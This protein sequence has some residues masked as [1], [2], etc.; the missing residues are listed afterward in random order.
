MKKLFLVIV[1]LL[2]NVSLPAQNV[3]I[4]PG[5]TTTIET[6]AVYNSDFGPSNTSGSGFSCNFNKGR[7]ILSIGA[8]TQSD[9]YASWDEVHIAFYYNGSWKEV[10]EFWMNDNQTGCDL[11]T[12][13]DINYYT[14]PW[15]GC[16]YSAGTYE[17]NSTIPG[18][19][20]VGKMGG[21]FS[22]RYQNITLK[23]M[24]NLQVYHG[25]YLAQSGVLLNRITT[26]D[27]YMWGIQTANYTTSGTSYP[28]YND[29]NPSTKKSTGY[30]VGNY[31]QFGNLPGFVY[32]QFTPN[33]GVVIINIAN[34]PPD[35]LDAPNFK[36]HIYA[37]SNGNN[38]NR[39]YE[40]TYSNQNFLT[41][42]PNTLTAS[43]NLCGKVTLNW[44]NSN[45][46]LPDDGNVTIKNV[47]FRNGTYLATID[48]SL[49]TYDDV[50]AVQDVTYKYTVKHV[51]FSETGETYY[52][53]PASAVAEGSVKP[54]PEQPISPTASKNTCDGIINVGWSFNGTNPQYFRLDYSTSSSGP[55]TT[56]SSTITGSSRSYNHTGA[57]RGQQYYYRIY[58]INSCGVISTTYADCNGIS[59]SDPALPTPV[60]AVLNASQDTIT[61]SWIDNANNETKYQIQ[62]QDNLGNLVTYDVN[63]NITSF[64]DYG[65]TACRSYTYS[66][67]VFN[68]CVQSGLISS[69]ISSG[70][71]P[72][73]N[74]NTTFTSSKKL[75]CSKGYFTN[76]VELNWTN[77]YGQN[78][79]IFKIYRKING[80][81]FDSTLVGTA[82]AGSGFYVDNTADARV[83]YKYTIVGIK[84][85]NGTD[86]LSNTSEDIGF[87][88][89][90]GVVSGHIE[91]NGGIA[92]TGAKVIIQQAG[93]STGSSLKFAAGD[94]L[95]LENP[96]TLGLTNQLRMEFW[97]K[98]TSYSASQN[99]INKAG[100]FS[101]K[102]TGSSYVALI[103]VGGTNYTL[104][105]PEA[106]F[107][108]NQWKHVSI[109]YLGDSTR[110]AL[111]AD[112]LLAVSATVPN[113]TIN[114]IS[115]QIVMGG[116]S[117]AFLMDEF[118]L[119]A[120][121]A[122]LD[123]TIYIDH[124][125]FLN[126]S[127]SGSKISLHFDE[128]YGDHAYDGSSQS[129]VFNGNHFIKTSG[130]TWSLDIPSSGQLSYF[131][132]TDALG[133]YNV[134]GVTFSGTGEN[135]TII[136]S[137]LTHSFTPSSRS[138]FIGDAS[139]VFNN[140]DFI[141]NSS[142]P[143]SGILTYKGTTCPV[144]DAS[145]KIDGLPVILNGQAVVT[146]SDGT[147]NISVPI[148]NHFIT[149]ERNAHYMESGRFPTSGTYDFQAPVAGITFV[150]STKRSI[151]GRV[152]GG[153]KE[154]DKVPGLGRSKNNIGQT[155]IR[156]VS[157]VTGVPCYT[158]EIVT[159][160]TTGEYRF[161]VPPLQYR[162]DSLYVLNNK[163]VLTASNS[164]SPFTNTNQ[165]IDLRNA[166]ATTTAKDSVFNSTGTW[167]GVVDSTTYHIR[168]DFVYLIT[169]TVSVT[170]V[171][172]AEFI[173]EDSLRFGSTTMSIKP[174]PT[175]PWG[176]MN[177]PVFKQGN[178]YHA[179]ILG[180]EIYTNFDNNKKD[181]VQL[182]GN[183]RLT[184]DLI[185]GSDPTPVVALKNGVAIYSF[186]CGEP[187]N[188]THG[189]NAALD[190]TKDLQVV[191]EPQGA[192]AVTW[193][194]NAT[195]SPGYP[196]YHAIVVG[197]KIT[198][199]GVATQGPEK[200]DF[201][202]RDP[203]GSGSSATWGTGTTVTQSTSMSKG[204]NEESE[205][206][207][208]LLLG[209]KA[210]TG[211]IAYYEE[212][213]VDNTVGLG[214][215]NTYEKTKEDTYTETMTTYS[216]VSTRDDP[217]NVGAPADIFIGRSKNWLVG[218]T[219][220]I[221]LKD[222]ASCSVG[223]NC[224]GP[225]VNGY[226][227]AKTVGYAIAPNGIRT[228]F[229]Y[230][231]N[232]IETIVIP[233]LVS[234]RNTYF[235]KPNYTSHLPASDPLFGINN[236]DPLLTTRST[237]TPLVYEPA[238]TTGAS[239]TFR[240]ILTQTDSVRV[241]NTQIAL[242]KQA[243]A[244]NEREK[245]QCVNNTGGTLI[246]NFT[247]GS[248]IVNNT[249]SVDQES[250]HTETY[251]LALGGNTKAEFGA[252]IGGIGFKQDISLTV[253][254]TKGNASSNGVTQSS[255]F[256]YTLTDGDPGD[257][258]SIDVYKS[259]EGTGNIFVTRGG[260][261][262][263][264]YED[265]VV[266]HYYNPS[267]PNGYIGSHS[268]N[269]NGYNTISN[270]TVKREEP[271]I[272]I[273]PSY[274]YSTPSNQAAT[275]QLILSN[276]SALS[277]NNDIDLR[278]YL[279]SQSNPN[280]AIVKIDGL[281]PNTT[282][283]IPTGA[284]VIKTLTI[285]RGPIEINYDSLMVIF[286]SVCSDD[287]ADTAYI[288]AHFIPTCTDLQLTSP[289]NNWVFNNSIKDTANI[290]VSNYNYNYGSA[291][292]NST[293][294]PTQLG[295]N[296]IGVE[297]RPASTN[298]WSEFES[299]Y[300]YPT[301]GQDTIPTDKIYSQYLWDI[302]AMPDGAYELKSKSY[303]LNRDGSFAIVESPIHSG[304]IDRIN[305]HPF[306]TPSPA[307][308][309]L[310]PNDDISIK[311][312]E[313]I[314]IGSLSNLNFDVRGVL[315]GGSS[316]QNESL[317]FDGTSSYAE[318]P[319]GAGLQK[320]DFTFEFWAQVNG[321]GVN[322]TVIS[323]GTDAS[324]NV[325]IGFDASN[326]FTFSMGS[327][328]VAS[329]SPVAS[330]GNW[331]HYAAVYDYTAQTASLY[332]DGSLINSGNTT[333]LFDYN[334]QGKL[335]FGKQLPSNTNYFNGNLND[336]RLWSKTR[337]MGDIVLNMNKDLNRSTSGLLYD[338]KMNEAYGT[339]THDVIR[340]RDAVLH[341]TT[342]HISP[343]GYAAQ[344]DGVDDRIDIN[345]STISITKEMDFTLEFWFKSN[346]SGVAT[347]FSNGKGD[348]LGADS[349]YAW[350]VAKDAS[351][352]IHVY[353]K[354]YDFVATDSNY[355]DNTWHHFALIMQRSANL[356]CYIDGNLQKSIQALSFQQMGGPYMYL[357]ARGYY[358]GMVANY[359]NNYNG[360]MDEFRFWNT[361]RKAEQILRDKQN[362]MLGDEY[363]L[364]AF[365][366]FES[367]T[368]N[369]GVPVLGP[370]IKDYSTDITSVNSD[371][372][373]ARNGVIT[374]TQTPTI[375]LP[376]PV[377]AISFTY[378][379]NNDQIIITPTTDPALIENVTLDIT[380]KDVYDLHGNK[381]QSPKTW[382]AYVNKNQVL[383]QDDAL[384]FTKTSDSV[385]TFKTTIINIGGSL[386]EYA[387]GG[388]PSWL[389]TSS[390]SES[391]A[392]NSAQAINF[393]IPAGTQI[394]EYSADITLTTD[395]GYDEIL[396]INLTVVG[397][398]PK[399]SF[400]PANFQYSMNIFGQ[401]KIDGVIATNTSTKIA[402][403]IGDTLCG[404]GNLNYLSAYDR[405]EVFLNVYSNSITGDTIRFQIYDAT[406][407]ITFVNV[408]PSEMFVDNQIVG[409]VSTPVTF[410]ANSEVRLNI[411]LKKGWTWV[412][413]PLKSNQLQSSN[414]LMA[415]VTN[416][417]NDVI[418][419]ISSYDQYASSM[420]WLGNIS[421]SPQHFQNNQSYK[422]KRA[423]ADTLALTGVRIYPDSSAAAIS[424]VPGWNW[425]GYVATKN[426]NVNSAMSNYNAVTGDLLKSQYEFAYY[427]NQTGWVGSLT[428]MRPGLGYM[429][430]ST[431]TSSFHYP[432]SVY[433]G[434]APKI[435]S[436]GA[437]SN[438][439][440][441][442][443]F[444]FAP[445]RYEKTM[446]V[447]AQSNLCN[448][449]KSSDVVLAAFDINNE[450]RGYATPQYNDH[451]KDYLYYLT[452]YGNASGETLQLK[453]VHL[454]DGAIIT[455]EESISFVPDGLSGSP[456]DPVTANVNSEVS[457]LFDHSNNKADAA[458]I[459]VYPNPFSQSLEVT[460][461]N[462]VN[463]RIEL[464]DG[465]G[466][467][468]SSVESVGCSNA[469]LN[470]SGL[471]MPG[472]VYMLKI[473][474]DINSTVK[475]VK[476]GN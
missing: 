321:S 67:K 142:F 255:S 328:S 72:P 101:F 211:A 149:V 353:H 285:E 111:F 244:Q 103:N 73:P 136:P 281:S 419:S 410:V 108:L 364:V 434:T 165:L 58:A 303:C 408:A 5:E 455:S 3:S 31:R 242:W 342:W 300:K 74:L 283:T 115:N 134:S 164:P 402:A 159:D 226:R 97:F 9:N 280:G 380:V 317:N 348:G 276:Q 450:L 401:L 4:L 122:P 289:N 137:Y 194:P 469:K 237:T 343:G 93:A 263:C 6:A 426:T 395:F 135:F 163:Y 190:Y 143:V 178:R 324:Q 421:S 425:I 398:D 78:I 407:G 331:H 104:S 39:I 249:Y 77:N 133:N 372:V 167:T 46:P 327:Q 57:T 128:N 144:P 444:T 49:S 89:P 200:V 473:S 427:D 106:T 221:E 373:F 332:V 424:V 182:D 125:R 396:H 120:L 64:K 59:I 250:S 387:I 34:L 184:N 227:L 222:T 273:T 431:V 448:Q 464:T 385:I 43:Q 360:L 44:S 466:K 28:C 363:G 297:F 69:S 117:S 84:Y 335:V 266:L 436:T 23:N 260:Q 471:N 415:N 192:A 198:G 248:A 158:A 267:N 61:L 116:T 384:T 185:T 155:K 441:H 375:K 153:L 48:G 223:I 334:G 382:I 24:G 96:S 80:T 393:K 337:T 409:N 102:H 195:M 214:F 301:A 172:G 191:L 443:Y 33:I 442:D 389:T 339:V 12:G 175:E 463:V 150:D 41:Q 470:F 472:G 215:S 338:W 196:N 85:C 468:Y 308:G 275:Y 366:P 70:I 152:V 118:R 173:G 218:P 132:V 404:V 224:F 176:P 21:G 127:V 27:N 63:P 232:E 344:F 53:S 247:L 433:Y 216:T 413:L 326:H 347:L 258:M 417:D 445:E 7:G 358:T 270:A 114:N 439:D 180:S 474:G 383:W 162:I 467:V 50:T 81:T 274:Q 299:F 124:A 315:N 56:L 110:F 386:K 272:V 157:P 188:S 355:F 311:F 204:V 235:T 256:E 277:V 177:W 476:T 148:G 210:L 287:I 239:Y 359:D 147:F 183:V 35:M 399:W 257:I 206:T 412:S 139:S 261:T 394:G 15:T 68:D 11:T 361:A 123:T 217:D 202:L 292:D 187:N 203:P 20:K 302:S 105:V 99:I 174:T 381:M 86:I 403:F 207:T 391:I 314:D 18:A 390:T 236:D 429:L 54:S 392:P 26:S 130:V 405:Y 304:V 219:S 352:K 370:S 323:Q 246:D 341:G 42:G 225:I 376:R 189:A 30:D 350:N 462:N 112:G 294:P 2:Y 107:P 319:A 362:R 151:I 161:E 365:V 16:T 55:F 286:A 205:T 209:K 71:I 62:R 295:F 75:I 160:A 79:D 397:D 322:Q 278:I 119:M 92:L 291:V 212:I 356:S 379:V 430:Q 40:T 449:L 181:T 25:N 228:R 208:S 241:I 199:T 367:Y 245:Y 22:D 452:I 60:S 126:A 37:K 201:I 432:L 91:Y 354:G 282:Y 458:F 233:G 310:D 87:R 131:G 336:M 262:M 8:E 279:A 88:N 374:T 98:P 82:A 269:A 414:L 290:I 170:G 14:T 154:A 309:I 19:T 268:Y 416:S 166:I 320:R 451:R 52:R 312:N 400:N 140:Q 129:N 51:A 251:E 288:S 454:T 36:V 76:R 146:A 168:K 38:H 186:T 113:G 100:V 29:P 435:G 47:I 94:T 340:S 388:L 330:I 284:S 411:P 252:E 329:I 377:E 238:D 229:S 66:I 65:I 461:T 264:P 193:T 318:V 438:G 460:F 346:Q 298:V 171:D 357:G 179:I 109:Q 325:A 271:H 459:N 418:R 453:Y 213:E 253:M 220:N 447:I 32:N 378:S 437:V 465:L 254:E 259:S 307:D 296:K 138:V 305:P 230:T 422:I 406:T 45:N 306:G 369:L 95:T 333:I 234:I 265:A 145:L 345:S 10:C 13:F 156:I 240:G 446:S 423:V 169:P 141:D 371:S 475:I 368:L 349:L 197:Q 316:R 1:I 456:A 90:T 243:L 121:A 440:I 420:G 351:G 83:Y 17:I 428:T 231:Q 293:T 313:S 457:C